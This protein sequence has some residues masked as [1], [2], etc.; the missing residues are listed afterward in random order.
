MKKALSTIVLSSF[1]VY[2]ILPTLAIRKYGIGI[3][4]KRHGSK[5]IALTFDDGPHPLYTVELLDLLKKYGV[6]ATFFVVGRKVE[7][8]PEIIER[9]DREGHMIGIHHFNH[10]SNWLLTPGRLRKE[11]ELT[12]KA[13]M[14][15]TNEKALI[16]RPPWGHFNLF[17]PLLSK[18]YQIVMW[19]NIFKDWKIKNSK[20]LL[21]PQLRKVQ[22]DGSILLLHD[23]GETFGADKT[24]PRY[25]L[26]ALDIF[27]QESIEKKTAFFTLKDMVESA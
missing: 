18:S 8:Y 4:K 7:K 6:K 13:I 10:I 9:M 3:T 17:T 20:N 25:M 22:E 2:S 27:L 12:E 16:Y 23:D 1:L 19:S 14:E 5:G 15:C 26:R 11:M 24:A 21:L